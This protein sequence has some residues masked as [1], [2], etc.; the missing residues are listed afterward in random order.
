MSPPASRSPRP[1]DSDLASQRDAL[2]NAEP[3]LYPRDIAARLKVTEA[4]IVALDEPVTAVRLRPCWTSLFGRLHRVG[5]VMALTRNADAVHEKT[6]SYGELQG[7]DTVGLFLGEAIDLRL[8]FTA[9]RFAWAVT[10]AEGRR[11]IQVFGADGAA[12]HKVFTTAATDLEAWDRLVAAHAAPHLEPPAIVPPAPLPRPVPDAAV[13]LAGF[14]AAWDA[15][16]DTHH[17]NALL[18]RFGV[19][20]TQALR[21]AGAARARPVAPRSLRLALQHAAARALPIMVF[22]ANRG[23]I[24]IHAGPVHHL[25]ETGPWFNVLDPGFSLHLRETAIAAAWVVAK[26]TDDGIVTSLEL[27]DADGHA[28]AA[29]FGRRKPGIPEDL[30][31]RALCAILP[32]A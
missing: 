20:R 10:P 25:R 6:G 12:V 29:L 23:C 16:R 11:S 9:W 27:F 21:L 17:F 19:T 31:W 15:L 24:Q 3:R 7:G 28:I 26:P 4:E 32:G 30:D 5:E 14:T 2:R 18:T 1:T 22:V 13:D 8:F